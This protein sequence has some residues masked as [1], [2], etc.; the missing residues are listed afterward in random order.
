[1]SETVKE[2]SARIMCKPVHCKTAAQLQRSL[3][4]L[5]IYINVIFHS[6]KCSPRNG[7]IKWFLQ[8]W[9]CYNLKVFWVVNQYRFRLL[10]HAWHA[11]SDAHQSPLAVTVGWCLAHKALCQEAD[12]VVNNALWGVFDSWLHHNNFILYLSRVWSRSE[13]WF[14]QCESLMEAYHCWH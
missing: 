9:I 4:L 2:I 1:M 10:C 8:E 3:K 14:L 12:S 11:V 7:F 13:K 6:R 5:Y